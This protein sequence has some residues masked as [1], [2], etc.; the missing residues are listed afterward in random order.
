MT[1][2]IE[3]LDEPVQLLKQ[4]RGWLAPKGRILIAVP[5]AKSLHRYIGVKLGMLPR[6]D[7]FN[8]QDVI[9]GHKRVYSSDLLRRHV[10]EAGL[11]LE[12]FGGLMVKPLS[13]RQIEKQW[14]N[15]LIEAFF[16]ISEDL[17]ELCSEIYV[18]ATA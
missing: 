18:V 17:P 5:N 2:I 16:A 15:E 1:H 4:A 13:N 3:H 14:S 6:I 8:E 11:S 7:A 12:K 9:L 10:A